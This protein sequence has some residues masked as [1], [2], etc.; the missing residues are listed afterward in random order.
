MWAPRPRGRG[1]VCPRPCL[2]PR[3]SHLAA[4]R[5][6]DT[7]YTDI[8]YNDEMLSISYLILKELCIPLIWIKRFIFNKKS[9]IDF[10]LLLA[11]VAQWHKRVTGNATVV[12]SVTTRGNDLFSNILICSVW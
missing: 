4:R 7:K 10:F 2:E 12:E 5:A 3:T 8:W 11:V 9:F 1:P 6:V